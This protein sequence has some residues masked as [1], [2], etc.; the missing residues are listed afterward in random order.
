[1]SVVG[2]KILL[3]GN[4]GVGKGTLFHKLS[5]SEINNK[6]ISTIFIDRISFQLDINF[7]EEEKEEKKIFDISLFRTAGNERYKSILYKDFKR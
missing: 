7:N 6:N 3:F 4:S 2:Y 1:M 5:N